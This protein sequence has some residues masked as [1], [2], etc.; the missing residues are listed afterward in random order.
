MIADATC[1]EVHLCQTV[2]IRVA[3]LAIDTDI[4]LIAAMRLDETHTLNEHAATAAAGVVDGAVVWLDKVGYQLHD[5]LGRI[6]LSVLL[7]GIDG[8]LL[9]EILIHTTYEVD[10]LEVAWVYF[11]DVIHDTLQ[12]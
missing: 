4:A 1:G 10:V 2:G 11:V 7:G 6:K 3:L 8:K 9:E 12:H 5:A